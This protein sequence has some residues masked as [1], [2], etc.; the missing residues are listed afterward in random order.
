MVPVTSIIFNMTNKPR[1]ICSLC[2]AAWLSILSTIVVQAESRPD[3]ARETRLA[4]QIVDDI[5]DGE[6]IWLEANNHQFLGIHTLNEEQNKGTVLILHGRGYHPD[7]PEVAGPLRTGLVDAGWSTLSIQ[8][9]VLEKGRLYYDYL[10][11]FKFARGRI[12]SAISYI[13][14]ASDQPII[15]AAHS[16][17]AHMANDWLNNSNDSKINGYVIMG[18]G[19]TDYRQELKTP[20]PFAQMRVPVL[21]LYGELEFPRPIAMLPERKALL[22]A[23][24]NPG[25]K[26]IMLLN[27]DHYF[28]DAGAPLTE[29][30]TE[31][32]NSTDFST[33]R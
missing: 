7:W 5:F 24:G 17:G 28:H 27:A 26:Q 19:A 32:L 31:W 21:D 10:P 18:A 4:E 13:A 33:Q 14:S 20:L 16:C 3:Y 25:S 22:D 30:V 23:G 8:M 11:L 1:T 29:V 2:L 12:E 6:P 9:P 15:L